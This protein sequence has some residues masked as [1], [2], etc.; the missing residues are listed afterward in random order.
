M[1]NEYD[2]CSFIMLND[3]IYVRFCVGFFCM[4]LSLPPL[5]LG[6]NRFFFVLE[7]GSAV[8]NAHNPDV[9][10]MDRCGGAHGR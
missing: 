5:L 6:D 7:E 4:L 10:Q 2:E 3:L 8:G 9:G 1:A